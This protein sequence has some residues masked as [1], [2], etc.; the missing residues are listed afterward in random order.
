[1]ETG[2]IYRMDP[3]LRAFF[4][5]LLQDGGDHEYFFVKKKARKYYHII[6]GESDW[7][8][9]MGSFIKIPIEAFEKLHDVY[10]KG[11]IPLSKTEQKQYFIN[12]IKRVNVKYA[13]D[14]DRMSR[15]LSYVLDDIACSGIIL[16]PKYVVR[17]AL[18]GKTGTKTLRQI[19]SEATVIT[20]LDSL[21]IKQTA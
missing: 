3:D 17:L 14:P 10:P 9:G 19:Y 13:K 20:D 15:S 8:G 11:F 1:M 4:G 16:D 21:P 12:H 5:N 7:H 6:A 18:T 2:K